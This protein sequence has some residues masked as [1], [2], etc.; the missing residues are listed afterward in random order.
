MVPLQKFALVMYKASSMP[1]LPSSL[2]YQGSIGVKPQLDLSDRGVP[3]GRVGV[4]SI[5]PGS[6]YPIAS[7]S[8]RRHEGVSLILSPSI[9]STVPLPYFS[10]CAC[11]CMRMSPC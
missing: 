2:S 5:E 1:L 11:A 8:C 10:W 3:R 4:I 7:D 9:N 6:Y